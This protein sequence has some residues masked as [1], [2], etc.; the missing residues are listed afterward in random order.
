MCNMTWVLFGHNEKNRMQK[1]ENNV[2][3]ANNGSVHCVAPHLSLQAHAV[4]EVQT[5]I[6]MQTEQMR[7]QMNLR[8]IWFVKKRR[9]KY[10]RNVRSFAQR[11]NLPTMDFGSFVIRHLVEPQ[12]RMF[13]DHFS[14]DDDWESEWVSE[15]CCKQINNKLKWANTRRLLANNGVPT[16]SSWMQPLGRTHLQ[17]YQFD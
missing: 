14:Y 9:T 4:T 13:A 15:S 8:L 16:R 17:A 3:E 1:T 5:E 11:S 6:Q 2:I 10:V 12:E 7:T